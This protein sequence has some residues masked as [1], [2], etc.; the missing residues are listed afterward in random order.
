M[1]VEAG[2]RKAGGK[3]L[4]ELQAPRD[5]H[6]DV[7]VGQFA[8]ERRKHE[9]GKDEDRT[10]HRHQWSA[11]FGGHAIEQ[12]D[13]ERILQHI[14]VQRRTELRPEQRGEATRRQQFLDHDDF[15]LLRLGN[16]GWDLRIGQP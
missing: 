12:H 5:G 15:L 9:E 7:F 16:S 8:A 4:G 1:H 13:D 14:V 10:G 6:L 11:F 2:G 3:Y